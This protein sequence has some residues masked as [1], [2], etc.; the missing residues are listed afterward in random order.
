MKR[1]LVIVTAILAAVIVYGSLY[2][3]AFRVPAA[4]S[5]ALPHL[6]STWANRPGRG[7]LISNIALY[8]PLGFFALRAFRDG[9][10]AWQRLAL[11]TIFGAT[12][13]LAM[14][15]T[16][17]FD[18]GRDSTLLDVYT[19]V[20]GTILGAVGGLVL[21]ERF[22]LP[23]LGNIAAEREAALL[24][25]AWLCYR[26]FPYVP[27]IDLHKYWDALKPIVFHPVL[28]P[29]E[30]FRHTTIWLAIFLLIEAIF[31]HRRP[32]LCILAFA[33]G[34]VFARILIIGSILS[35]AEIA[36]AVLALALW[37]LLGADHRL[38]R[39]AIA[40]L[41]LGVVTAI[42]LEPFD[43]GPA[44][45]FNWTPFYGFMHGSVEVDVQ[46]FCE[47]C[48]LY[49]G[50]IWLLGRLGFTLPLA[51]ITVALLLFATSALEIFLPG[52][53]AEVTDGIIALA[54]GVAAALTRPH[55]AKT[56]TV[57]TVPLR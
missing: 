44:G 51:T 40:L 43:F 8:I 6:L 36:G 14:E 57:A 26:L 22:T 2:P 5:D 46:A 33:A 10:P 25:V 38:R 39:V 9:I 12:L 52:R 15:Y 1:N 35:I 11:V 53:S 19:N 4:D 21:G 24:I 20:T 27:A 30:L 54:L 7:D 56:A 13:S 29:Y 16:Q 3:F 31:R 50:S 45:A 18:Q 55:P 32:F 49:G 48:F 28:T 23:L 17:F 37:L 34:V 42:R 41:F 47:K